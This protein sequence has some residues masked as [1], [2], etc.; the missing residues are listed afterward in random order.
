MRVCLIADTH[1]KHENLLLPEADL[2]IHCGDFFTLGEHSLNQ[3]GVI[4]EWFGRAPRQDVVCI[5]GNHDRFLERLPGQEREPFKHAHYLLDSTITVEGLSIYG[6]PWC[7]DL[8]GFAFFATTEELRER[9]R[10]IPTGIDILVTHTPPLGILDRPSGG[11][12]HLGCPILKEELKRI[13]P[14]VHVFGH[15]HASYGQFMENGTHFIN[16]ASF[17]TGSHQPRQAWVVDLVP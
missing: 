12:V 9:W 14:R 6:T 10:K 15:I 16:A 2:L 8:S 1:G 17:A 13:R 5:A 4:D 11:K 7:P 3:V